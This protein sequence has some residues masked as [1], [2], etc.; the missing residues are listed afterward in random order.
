MK[1]VAEKQVFVTIFAEECRYYKSHGRGINEAREYHR[2]FTKREVTKIKSEHVWIDPFSGDPGVG[3]NFFRPDG[4]THCEGSWNDANI[5]P[6]ERASFNQLFSMLFDFS[7]K[8][9]IESGDD[10]SIK[11]MAYLTNVLNVGQLLDP[12]IKSKIEY[13]LEDATFD[14]NLRF[15]SDL[16]EFC[17]YELRDNSKVSPA[18]EWRAKKF[19]KA[20]REY[21]SEIS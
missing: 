12:E 11:Y 21:A 7:V 4:F 5:S 14:N 9:A 16:S 20:L 15:R 3:L 17:G 18:F 19:E 8:Y 1:T 2:K 13:E 10:I 6:E